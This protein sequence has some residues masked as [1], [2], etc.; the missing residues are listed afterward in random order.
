MAFADDF[1]RD[2]PLLRGVSH[3]LAAVAATVGAAVLLLL[4]DSP[5]TYVS[6]AIFAASLILLYA[7]SAA[8]HWITWTPLFRAIIS[9][10]DHSMV[11]V[12]IG[13]TYTP[14]CLIVLNSA[15]GISMLSVVW[16][17]VGAGILINL[18]W[19]ATPN[20][21]RVTFYLIVGWL[22]LVSSAELAA[23]F[24]VTPLMLLVMGGVFYTL[25]GVVYAIRKPDPW[26]QVFG[27]LEVFHLLVIAG[28]TLHYSLVAIYV[29]PS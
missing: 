21:L 3:L 16:G 19:P 11:L 12:L 20:W 4:A 1:A 28:S 18:A 27:Y 8:Y 17:V 10:M 13:G 9:R 6:G 26:P 24:T 2:R 25:S 7:T 29:L 15:W 23:W 14:F 5:R 22:A